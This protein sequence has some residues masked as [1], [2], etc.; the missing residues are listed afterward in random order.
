MWIA[1]YQCGCAEDAPRKRDLL[2]Y[3]GTHG[4][5]RVELLKIPNEK[6]M[7]KIKAVC[8]ALKVKDKK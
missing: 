6:D 4:G 2:D 5:E 8:K 1:R 3:C 7:E